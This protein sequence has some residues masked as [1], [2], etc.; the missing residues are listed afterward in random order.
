MPR[1]WPVLSSTRS[2]QLSIQLNC[3]SSAAL[4]ADIGFDGGRLQLP[5]RVAQEL[6]VAAAGIAPESS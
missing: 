5:K 4:R 3:R 1:L 6:V 2:D